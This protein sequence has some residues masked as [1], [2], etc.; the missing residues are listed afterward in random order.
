MHIS[1]RNTNPRYE[2]FLN[3]MALEETNMEKDLGIYVTSNW[4]S[5][6]HVAK[7][8]AKANSV[9]GRIRHTFTFMNK[10]IFLKVYPS[11]VRTHLEYA[12]QA[13][14]PQLK[15]DITVLE[16][17]QKRATRLVP[18]LRGLSYEQRLVQLG[19]TTLEE[20][21]RRGDL[22]EVFKIMHGFDNL[23]RT[24]FFK[25]RKEV[26]SHD[27]KGHEL[28]IAH[29]THNKRTRG[30]YF[31]IR[32]INDWNMLPGEVVKYQSVSSF[33]EALDRLLERRRT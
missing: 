4:R 24:K 26:H 9:L 1:L 27:T 14:S 5:S 16:K 20:R 21:R 31:D 11:L 33:K 6:A 18:E 10:H 30:G 8:A 2:Y 28:R 25:L 23:D 19:L 29:K 3:D 17:V 15:K 7:A 13:W 32:I 22:I 12:V